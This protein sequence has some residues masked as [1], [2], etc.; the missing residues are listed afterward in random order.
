MNVRDAFE[1][2]EHLSR[3]VVVARAVEI[4]RVKLNDRIEFTSAVSLAVAFE[5]GRLF[6]RAEVGLEPESQGPADD[7]TVFGEAR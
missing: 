3:D 1:R 5:A 2:V 6:S 4:Q 7:M